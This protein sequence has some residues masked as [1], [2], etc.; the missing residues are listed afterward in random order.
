MKNEMTVVI[1][2]GRN[3]GEKPM[4]ISEWTSFKQTVIFELGCC[5]A[6]VI[7]RPYLPANGTDAVGIWEGKE[8]GAATFIAF[9][10]HWHVSDLKDALSRIALRYGQ[11][12]IGFIEHPRT[13]NLIYAAKERPVSIG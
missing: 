3:I 12:T 7:Q 10:Q 9:I 6:E 2:I 4:T 1:M 8:E 13:D 5:D 11:Q